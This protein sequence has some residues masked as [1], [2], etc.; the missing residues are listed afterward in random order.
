MDRPTLPTADELKRAEAY[1][2]G[3]AKALVEAYLHRMSIFDSFQ[4][5]AGREDIRDARHARLYRYIALSSGLLLSGGSLSLCVYAMQMHANIGQVALVLAPIGVLAG[6]FLNG[7]KPAA[8]KRQKLPRQ[9][10]RTGKESVP[11][12]PNG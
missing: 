10:R 12:L 8:A 1:A 7:G 5:D 11:A 2:P 9:T 6:V 4:I 3:S